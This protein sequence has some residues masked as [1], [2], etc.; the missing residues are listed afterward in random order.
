MGIVEF[1]ILCLINP[2]LL[3]VFSVLPPQKKEN[4][5]QPPTLYHNYKYL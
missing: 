4:V 1:D 2:V 3:K 5:L